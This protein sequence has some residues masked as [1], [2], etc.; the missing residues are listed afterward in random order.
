METKVKKVVVGVVSACLISCEKVHVE[1]RGFLPEPLPS[2]PFSIVA[3]AT[4][5]CAVLPSRFVF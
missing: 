2:K 3:T 1:A 4:A 5:V